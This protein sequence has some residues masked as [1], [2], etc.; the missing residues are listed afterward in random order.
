[1]LARVDPILKLCLAVGALLAGAGVGYY[2][3]IFLPAQ[4]VRR[5]TLAMAEKQAKAAEQSRALAERARREQAAQS[6]YEGCVAFAETSYRQRWT[7]ACTAMHDAD[8]AAFEDCADDLFSSER[9]CLAR[10]PIRPAQDCALPSETAQALA[11]ARDERKGQCLGQLQAAQQGRSLP[12][13]DESG[14]LR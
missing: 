14:S 8:Q 12:Q 1:M 7:Q 10:R 11:A 4:D 2:Y 13:A 3:G 6:E 9:G 5:Q